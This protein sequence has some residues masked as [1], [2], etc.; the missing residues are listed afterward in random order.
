[1]SLGIAEIFI[2]DDCDKFF[3]VLNG[4]SSDL[5][6]IYLLMAYF[7][8]DESAS[9]SLLLS[10]VSTVLISKVASQRVNR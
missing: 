6:E 1:M 2:E 10:P 5:V 8:R 7:Q 3:I 9:S 4:N